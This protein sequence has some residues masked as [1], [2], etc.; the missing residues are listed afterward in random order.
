MLLAHFLYAALLA[1]LTVLAFL[2]GEPADGRALL[3]FAGAVTICAFFSLKSPRHG[4]VGAAVLSLLLAF[5]AGARLFAL[6]TAGGEPALAAFLLNATA[7]MAAAA[8][9]LVIF[10]RW[11]RHRRRAPVED[12]EEDP[13]SP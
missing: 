2:R 13:P 5:S 10:V 7:L 9:L 8:F 1:A 6:V 4:A 3:F 11:Q 12:G